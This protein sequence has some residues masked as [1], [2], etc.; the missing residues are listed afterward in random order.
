MG[1]DMTNLEMLNELKKR[2]DN[3]ATAVTVFKSTFH[4]LASNEI[5]SRLDHL[6]RLTRRYNTYT[7]EVEQHLRM[8]RS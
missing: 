5:A 2:G 4:F 7:W 8:N 1:A 3:L 6:D